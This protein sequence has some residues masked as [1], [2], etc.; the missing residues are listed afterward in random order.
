MERPIAVQCCTPCTDGMFRNFGPR[1]N[2]CQSGGQ[3]ASPP[4][5]CMAKMNVGNFSSATPAWLKSSLASPSPLPW[6]ALFPASAGMI[7]E[8]NQNTHYVVNELGHLSLSQASR[9]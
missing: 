4:L 8:S 3:L 1:M 6:L 5:V 7:Y 9:R 2:D